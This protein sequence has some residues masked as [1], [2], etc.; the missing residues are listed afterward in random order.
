MEHELRIQSCIERHED[1]GQTDNPTRTCDSQGSLILTSAKCKHKGHGSY[2]VSDSQTFPDKRLSRFIIES[3]ILDSRTKLHGQVMV[4]AKDTLHRHVTVWLESPGEPETPKPSNIP[5]S[6][7]GI[8][9]SRDVFFT[10]IDQQWGFEKSELKM[11]PLTLKT[12]I[13]H[14]FFEGNTK[15]MYTSG[16]MVVNLDTV[17]LSTSQSEVSARLRTKIRSVF[18]S[19]LYVPTLS[20]FTFPPRSSFV[21]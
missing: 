14:L 15:E 16:P 10:S 12:E 5:V 11:G 8:F 6:G 4:S 20:N 2:Y 19:R 9:Q 18:K 13:F 17:H 1:N 3:Y 21:F 7:G